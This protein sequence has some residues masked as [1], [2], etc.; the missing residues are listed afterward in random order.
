MIIYGQLSDKKFIVKKKN[1]NWTEIYF[2]TVVTSVKTH[3]TFL[4]KNKALGSFY[5]TCVVFVAMQHRRR[6][7]KILYSFLFSPYKQTK[8]SGLCGKYH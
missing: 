3:E 2:T 6:Y 1:L 4:D 8:K 5:S 7:S